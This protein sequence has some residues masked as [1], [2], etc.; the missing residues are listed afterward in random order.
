MPY[1]Q[2]NDKLK[3]VYVAAPYTGKSHLD[4]EKNVLRARIIGA[5]LAKKGFVPLI[6]HS[7]TA[8]ME[9]VPNCGDAQFWYDATLELL[10]RCDAMIYWGPE[11]SSGVRNEIA[12]AEHDKMPFVQVIHDP[13]EGLD[14]TVTAIELLELLMKPYT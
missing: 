14:S 12:Y 9:F 8:Y 4:V 7:N 10:A 3:L 6:P 11:K 5:E 2:K 1:F 13:L